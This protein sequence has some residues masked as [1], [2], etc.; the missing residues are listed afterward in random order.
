MSDKVMD[1]R[2]PSRKVEVNEAWLRNGVARNLPDAVKTLVDRNEI[3]LREVVELVHPRNEQEILDLID[4][5]LA[6]EEEGRDGGSVHPEMEGLRG[7]AES[8]EKKLQSTV[9]TALANEERIDET[10]E[11]GH[12]GGLTGVKVEVQEQPGNLNTL[13]AGLTR[14]LVGISLCKCCNCLK[15]PFSTVTNFSQ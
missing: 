13:Q 5:Q 14:N 2:D 15:R 11:V 6:K 8:P 12:D 4:A 9:T 1:P 10:V 7:Q 3:S